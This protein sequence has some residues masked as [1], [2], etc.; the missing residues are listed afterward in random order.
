MSTEPP[1][2]RDEGRDPATGG[3]EEAPPAGTGRNAADDATPLDDPPAPRAVEEDTIPGMP[4][5]DDRDD[6]LVDLELDEGTPGDFA[7]RPPSGPMDDVHLDADE[8]AR[9]AERGEAPPGGGG[10]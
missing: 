2:Q 5:G 8:A 1:F 9:A 4:P 7:P 3:R 6:D 10:R